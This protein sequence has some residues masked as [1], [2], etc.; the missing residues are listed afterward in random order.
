MSE[1]SQ[2]KKWQPVLAQESKRRSRASTEHSLIPRNFSPKRNS[3]SMRARADSIEDGTSSMPAAP[4]TPRNQLAAKLHFKQLQVTLPSTSVV[5]TT[6][7]TSMSV[8]SSEIKKSAVDGKIQVPWEF[9]SDIREERSKILRADRYRRRQERAAKIISNNNKINEIE[10]KNS[11]SSI[12]KVVEFNIDNLDDESDSD[13]ENHIVFYPFAVVTKSQRANLVMKHR[14]LEILNVNDDATDFQ[15]ASRTTKANTHDTTTHSDEPDNKESRA[16]RMKAKN[17]TIVLHTL[18]TGTT[19]NFEFLDIYDIVW[20]GLPTSMREPFWMAKLVS[21]SRGALLESDIPSCENLLRNNRLTCKCYEDIIKDIYRAYPMITKYR[22]KF[23]EQL[24]RSLIAYALYRPDIGF[25]Q[26]MAQIMSTILLI[27][28]QHQQQFRMMEFIT[29]RVLPLYFD[30]DGIGWRVDSAVLAAYMRLRYAKLTAFYE[31]QFEEDIENLTIELVTRWYTKLFIQILRGTQLLRIWDMILLR[32]PVTLIQFTLQILKYGYTRE[33][34][35][36]QMCY[37]QFI[38]TLQT[39]LGQMDNIDS[40]M[41]TTL[42]GGHIPLEDFELR[43]WSATRIE[44]AKMQPGA[45][46]SSIK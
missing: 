21:L 31:A 28:P 1:Q 41:K 44:L 15:T 4:S 29:Q 17:D 26:G 2:L 6:T 36:D 12:V 34:F 9:P 32:G 33:L 45:D 20:G 7:A 37:S 40:V 13:D 22:P 25:M 11:S 30:T 27:L 18:L 39:H 16:A 43:R 42:S 35:V 46:T 10:K 38:S 3:N 14:S 8:T 23:D 24:Y 5:T 19:C